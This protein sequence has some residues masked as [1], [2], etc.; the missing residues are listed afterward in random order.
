MPD[1]DDDDGNTTD[2]ASRGDGAV[3]GTKE[4]ER[5]LGEIRHSPDLE[6]GSGL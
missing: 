4:R 3:E 5:L 2:D 1:G 6:E